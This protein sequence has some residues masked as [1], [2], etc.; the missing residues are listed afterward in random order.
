MAKFKKA[1]EVESIEQIIESAPSKPKIEEFVPPP[2]VKDV[3]EVDKA[4][5]EELVYALISGHVGLWQGQ[6]AVRKIGQLFGKFKYEE[7][8]ELVS[9][10]RNSH[11]ERK[12]A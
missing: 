11:Y 7:Q 5:L 12:R 4:L 9:K 1:D 10:L 3:Y 2:K 8:R 6:G